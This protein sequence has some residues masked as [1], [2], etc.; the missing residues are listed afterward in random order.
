M[1]LS[2]MVLHDSDGDSSCSFHGGNSN[3]GRRDGDGGGGKDVK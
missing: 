3:I 1:V 2:V